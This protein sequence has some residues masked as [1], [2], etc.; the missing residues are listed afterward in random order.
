M[1]ASGLK[2]KQDKDLRNIEGMYCERP[3]FGVKDDGSVE[4]TSVDKVAII[5]SPFVE[6]DDFRAKLARELFKA[7]KSHLR[8]YELRDGILTI[9]SGLSVRREKV[10]VEENNVNRT[11]ADGYGAALEDGLNNYSVLV[12]MRNTY[13]PNYDL[14]K[15]T[16]LELAAGILVGSLNLGEML[17]V[18]EITKVTDEL[19]A[20][21]EKYSGMSY[22]KFLKMF[23]V[24][25]QKEEEKNR[26]I[27][28]DSFDEASLEYER[29]FTE[30]IAPV[31]SQM[32]KSMNFGQ[33]SLG[34][35]V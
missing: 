17:K 29:Y 12:L 14:P 28:T 16:N 3:H 33:N 35:T 24:L 7:V 34:I 8:A 11:Y 9:S 21:I 32:A 15:H 22:E 10:A 31:L 27:G 2:G 5:N 1:G 4:M 18:A 19:I 6:S 30:T 26:A 20:T 23:D 13:N 25:R